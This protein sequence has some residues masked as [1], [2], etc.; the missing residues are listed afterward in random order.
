VLSIVEDPDVESAMVGLG[1][2][3][4][5]EPIVTEGK[6]PMISLQ[7]QSYELA[8]AIRRLLLKSWNIDLPPLRDKRT[9]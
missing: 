5:P 3:V 7:D 4:P 9:K 2:L 1:D 6:L 8:H